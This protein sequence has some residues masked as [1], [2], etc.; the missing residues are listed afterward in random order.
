MT[1]QAIPEE[2]S[3]CFATKLLWGDGKSLSKGYSA[4]G[5]GTRTRGDGTG[6]LYL[7]SISGNKDARTFFY[8][9]NTE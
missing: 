8:V 6:Q 1:A 7:P 9:E 4:L 5:R 2:G 3:M